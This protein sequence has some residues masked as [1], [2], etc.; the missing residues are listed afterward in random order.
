MKLFLAPGILALMLAATAAGCGGEDPTPAEVGPVSI[1]EALA[2]DSDDPLL[3][4]GA[5]VAVGG[6]PARLCSALAESFPPQCGEPSLV[7]EG[8]S[9]SA[10][11]NLQTEGNVS[12]AE[13]VSLLGK[14]ENDVLNLSRP[15]A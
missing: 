12:W 10:V 2:S 11:A 7:V 13:R 8:L 14:V 15:N 4:E 3:V 9:L 1:A 6:E 5:L